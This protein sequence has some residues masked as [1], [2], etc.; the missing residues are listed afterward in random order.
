MELSTAVYD[1]YQWL[2]DGIEIEEATRSGMCDAVSGGGD[3]TVT[4]LTPAVE[5]TAGDAGRNITIDG[6][7]C[8]IKTF[9]SATTIVIDEV[10][11]RT[12]VPWSILDK[13][14]HGRSYM[15]T[16]TGDYNVR[17]SKDGG[18]TFCEGVPH[19]VDIWGWPTPE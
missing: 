2:K 12:N 8:L 9:V 18:T 5:F 14:A 17:V 7:E 10:L 15:V 1:S 3:S 19:H 11:D 16:E 4:N 6:Q 13:T